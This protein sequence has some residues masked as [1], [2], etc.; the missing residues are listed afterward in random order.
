MSALFIEN[1]TF[2]FDKV[3]SILDTQF[4]FSD[5]DKAHRYFLELRQVFIDWNYAAMDSEQFKKLEAAIDAKV[6]EHSHA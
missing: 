2:L 4:D 6:K 1:F 3:I 5:K